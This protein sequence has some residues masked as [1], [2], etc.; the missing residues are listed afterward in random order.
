M[1]DRRTPP[2]VYPFAQLTMPAETV[3]K[4]DNGLTFHH[5]SGGDQPICKLTLHFAG[6]ISEMGE[7]TAKVLASQVSEGTDTRS[8]EEIAEALDFGGVRLSTQSQAHHS[9]VSLSLLTSRLP[10]ILP[11]LADMISSPSFPADRL[12]VTRQRMINAIQIA[13]EDPSAVADL[14][15]QALIWGKDN[16]YAHE[17]SEPDIEAVDIVRLRECHTRLMC[18]ARIHAYFSGLLDDSSISSVRDFLR[19]IPALSSGFDI[20]LHP[21]KPAPGCSSIVSSMPS[22]MQSA[23]SCSLPAPSREHP[24]YVPL[25]LSVMAL[26]GYFGSRLMSNIREEKGLTYGINAAVMGNQDGAQV[27]IGTTTD[28]SATQLVIDEIRHELA[29]MASNPPSGDELERFRTYA[30]TGLA[31]QLDNPISVMQYYGSQNLVG[32]PVD[33]FERQQSVLSALTPDEISRISSLYL[34]PDKLLISKTE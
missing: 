33:Y 16:P 34:N 14:K 23:I 28:R 17:I 7:A 18:P 10:E 8:A 9:V 5:F 2:Q 11:V 20:E 1:P 25:R 12:A 29:D 15:L 4:L 32:T 19:N 30:M 3:E 6:G 26:G 21:A 22:T 31:E 13:R 27:Y 24:D